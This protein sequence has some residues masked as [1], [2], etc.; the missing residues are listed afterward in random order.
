MLL[1]R[2]FERAGI[3]WSCLPAVGRRLTFDRRNPMTPLRQRFI[4]DLQLRNYAANTISAYVP[5]VV[6]FA[7]HFRLSP[8]R[9]GAEHIR[10]Y[11]LHL[12]GQHVC[13]STFN[14]TVCALRFLYGITLQRPGLV[15]MIPYGKKPK[16][17]PAVLSQDEVRRLFDAVAAGHRR[18]LL[19]TAYAAGLRVSEV[20]RLNVSDIDSQR[21]VLHILHSKGHKDRLVPLSRL[22]LE[23]LRDYWRQHRPKHWLFPGRT[24]AGHISVGSV[25]RLCQQAVAAASITKKASMHTLR[26]SYATHLLE[27]GVDLP[28][29]QK[30]LGHN[31]VSTTLRYTHVQQTH[32]CSAGSPL[33]NLLARPDCPAEPVENRERTL[34]HGPGCDSDR[35]EH[36]RVAA[37]TRR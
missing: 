25:Q 14:Q 33:D 16:T 15:H 1:L 23:R 30:L 35:A 37:A 4:E 22:L 21:M 26:H 27:A 5:A 12:L 32:L 31:N 2:F 9:L 28:T 11:Q 3:L 19:E 29:L 36:R 17:L 20:V 18:L 6:R 7:L 10:Q 13:W 24:P 34:P 8:E